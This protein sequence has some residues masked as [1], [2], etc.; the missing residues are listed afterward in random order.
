MVSENSF[1]LLTLPPIFWTQPRRI[2]VFATKLQ[3]ALYIHKQEE[4]KRRGEIFVPSRQSNNTQQ[5]SLSLVSLHL[6]SCWRWKYSLYSCVRRIMW[7]ES[8]KK[9]NREECVFDKN[10]SHVPFSLSSRKTHGT[11]AGLISADRRAK[12]TLMLTIPC[13]KPSRLQGV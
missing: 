5:P 11:N 12:P 10:T 9:G 4:E 2:I 6:S 7:S 3:W 8:R 1:W 13:S